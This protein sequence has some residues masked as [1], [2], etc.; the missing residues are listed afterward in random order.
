MLRAPG[1][2]LLT[3]ETVEREVASVR[4]RAKERFGDA[5]PI[6]VI[7]AAID[8][9][10][11]RWTGAKVLTFVPLVVERY[12]VERLRRMSVDACSGPPALIT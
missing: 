12:S 8:A 11:A 7:D 4:R 1:V 6:D 9:Q 10:A 3:S 5:I 2:S